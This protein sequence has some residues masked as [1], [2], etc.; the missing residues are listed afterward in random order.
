MDQIIELEQEVAFLKQ[1]ARPKLI[2]TNKDIKSPLTS[3]MQDIENKL[4]RKLHL[5]NS[6]SRERPARNDHTEGGVITMRK[7]WQGEMDSEEEERRLR[8]T[9]DYSRAV[10]PVEEFMRKDQNSRKKLQ[11]LR[12]SELKVLQSDRLSSQRS[13][14]KFQKP[15][16][17]TDN[18]ES[19]VESDMTFQRD[20]SRLD[21]D[22]KVE[23]IDSTQRQ[24]REHFR[25]SNRDK[26]D[27][28]KSN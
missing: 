18:H 12:K 24:K 4:D 6:R 8:P 1:K 5:S 25:R 17:N 26:S 7:N 16:T 22:L 2:Q 10:S 15:K 20:K 11:I 27:P 14:D 21:D 28:H 9:S 13:R 23:D 3:M 19:E